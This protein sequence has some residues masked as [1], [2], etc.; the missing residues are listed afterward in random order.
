MPEESETGES[1]HFFNS[2]LTISIF[3]FDQAMASGSVA[4][5]DVQFLDAKKVEKQSE[6]R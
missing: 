4:S 3:Y 1:V 2:A 5:G 6:N